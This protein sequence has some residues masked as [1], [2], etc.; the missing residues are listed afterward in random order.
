MHD[1]HRPLGECASE[2]GV[3]ICICS[4]KR[5]EIVETLKA[6]EAQAGTSLA[7]V[8]VIVADN[9]SEGRMKDAIAGLARQFTLPLVYLHAPANNISIARNACLDTAH[10]AWIAFLDDDEIPDSHWLTELIE[11]AHRSEWDA[12]LGPV[13]A[14]YDRDAPAWMKSGKFHSTRPVTVGGKIRTGYTGNVLI[15]RALL[16][17]LGLRFR[18]ELGLSGGEDNDFFYRFTDGGGKIGFA[19][20][21][22][23]SERVDAKRANLAWLLRRS[24]RA[25]QSHG[26]R[27]GI[28]R[29]I[30]NI[31]LASSKAAYCFAAAFLNLTHALR[32]NR[33]LIRG[34]LHCGVVARLCG[35]NE[36]QVYREL[37]IEN[38]AHASLK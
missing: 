25:G 8:R 34:A 27:L 12:V 9:T 30:R 16:E 13:D 14:I 32:R 36:L 23:V 29:R 5:P 20:R 38:R 31:V 22:V 26:C 18:I 1:S 3:D 37:V 2:V 6:V 4:Y 15:R 10:A 21:A 28:E 19:D 7:G 33:S 11:E 17:A 24:F 35:M